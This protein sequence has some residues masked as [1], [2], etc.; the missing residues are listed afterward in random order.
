MM[1]DAD[2]N[3]GAKIAAMMIVERFAEN[4]IFTEN[5]CRKFIEIHLDEIQKGMLFKIK[6]F[7]LPT[8]L[9]CSKHL[10]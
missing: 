7:L 2:H 10:P 4:D 3:E 9:A 8:L 6:K 1:E 5:Q